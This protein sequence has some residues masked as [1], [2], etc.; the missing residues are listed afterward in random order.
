MRINIF[1]SFFMILNL[2]LPLSKA[3]AS[4]TKCTNF[5]GKKSFDV[6]PVVDSPECLKGTIEIKGK[7]NTV[8]SEKKGLMLVDLSEEDNCEDGCPIKRLPVSWNGT[9][10]LKGDAVL[11]SGTLKNQGS[12]FVFAAESLKLISKQ[13]SK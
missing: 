6:S 5:T 2:V 3:E 7:V 13:D 4:D 8:S 1:L 11:I 10:P 12:K 9:M